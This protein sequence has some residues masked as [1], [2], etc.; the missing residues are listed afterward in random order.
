MAFVDAANYNKV[1]SMRGLPI[2]SILPWSATTS[3]VPDGW[4]TCNG[5][6]YDIED[7]PL[8]YD[9]IGT[10]YGGTAGSTFKVPSI[11]NTPKGIVD[12][13]EGHFYYL[14]VEE[15]IQGSDAH[16]PQY[17]SK[18]A[19]AFWN[20]VGGGISGNEGSNTQTSWISTVDLVGDI[21][22]SPLF[23][24]SY[25]DISMTEGDYFATANYNGTKLYDY[26]LQSHGHGINNVNTGTATT[27]YN[28]SGGAAVR[29][30]GEWK[31]DRSCFV[32]CDTTQALRVRNGDKNANNSSHLAESFGYWETPQAGG[33]DVRPVPG[34]QTAS[35]GY[36][37]GDG[38]CQ[39]DMTCA[40]FNAND[41][42]LF[43]NLAS[44]S[45]TA[46]ISGVAEHN[47]GSNNYQF[48]SSF[49]V[50]NPGIR[51]DIS[52]NNVKIVNNSGVNFG[53]ISVTTSTA[54]LTMPFIIRAY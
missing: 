9:V 30:G 52:I 44:D 21:V 37:P 29:C 49:G 12:M 4:V 36:F 1:K 34:G 7:Y 11:N 51:N 3:Q 23:L 25:S 14:Q 31:G 28:R 19:D 13:F 38:R 6:I 45:E 33:G 15:H 48:S 26:H 53:T 8:L 47:H 54:T 10:V 17:T 46:S 43:T 35:G 50:I 18:S 20:I 16:K 24:A 41:R 22:S 2:G 27:S 32:T 5:K 39:G 40:S 42:I